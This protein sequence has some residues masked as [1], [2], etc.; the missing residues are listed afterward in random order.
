MA[1]DDGKSSVTDER[2]TFTCSTCLIEDEHFSISSLSTLVDVALV[3]EA[4]VPAIDTFALIA[5]VPARCT[6]RSNDFDNQLPLLSYLISKSSS[7]A[8]RLV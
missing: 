7:S 4:L 3:S 5:R 8:P 6:Q 2:V 1:G